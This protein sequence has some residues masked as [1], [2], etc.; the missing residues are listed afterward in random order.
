MSSPNLELARSIY[1]AWERGEHRQAEWAHSEA[2]YVVLGTLQPSSMTGMEHAAPVVE[3][4]LT[5]WDDCC[6]Q[7]ER[8]CEL[9]DQRVLAV[10]A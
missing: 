4:F 1:A 7:A 2:E 8:Y 5:F 10:A 3:D 6:V 9:D